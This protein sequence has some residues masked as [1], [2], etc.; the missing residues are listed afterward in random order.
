MERPYREL[1]F[2]IEA[3]IDGKLHKFI[4]GRKSSLAAEIVRKGR[5]KMSVSD[6]KSLVEQVLL[7]LARRA[8]L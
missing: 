2:R 7:P 1:S 8:A 3:V 5:G 4:A 6:I